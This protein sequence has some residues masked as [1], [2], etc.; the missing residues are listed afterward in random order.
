M[1]I[2]RIYT[3]GHSNHSV[4]KFIQLLDMH[5]INCVCDVRS[6]PYSRYIEQYNREE[7][8]EILQQHAITYLYFGEELGARREEKH[9]LTDGKVDFEKVSNDPKFLKGIERIET[10]IKKG[11]RIALMC[12]EKEPIRCHRAILVSRN[13][14]QRGMEVL[15]ILSDGTLIDHQKIEYELVEKYFPNH[16]QLCL[17]QSVDPVDYVKKAYIKANKEIGYQE[18]REEGGQSC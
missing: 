13:I 3:I 9:L 18:E 6:I 17:F 16:N 2:L 15:H 8:K 14:Y 10:G 1:N 11:Y 7:F 4:E 5:R 12:T